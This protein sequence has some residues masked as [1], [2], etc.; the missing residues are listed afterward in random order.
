MARG[1][2]A[3]R[4]Q[5]AGDRPTINSHTNSIGVRVNRTR[6]QTT[7]SDR[8]SRIRSGD[9]QSGRENCSCSSPGSGSV[10]EWLSCWS[11]A[12]KGPGFKLQPRRCRV[13]VLGKLF[14]PI[15]PV[16]TKQQNW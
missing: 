10:A 14:T 3:S 15:V 6:T 8:G 13:I 12:Q 16:F 1:E 4:I 2:G 7:S 11:Q 5:S 9:G